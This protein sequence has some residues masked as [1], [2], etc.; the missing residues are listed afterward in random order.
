MLRD[1][2]AWAEI[3]LSAIHKNVVKLKQMTRPN[4]RFMAVVKADGYGHGAF[5]VAR[6]ALS[7]GATNIGV[8]TID[9]AIALRKAGIIEPI[10]VLS[11][12]P[13]D[14][15]LKLV[16][17]NIT[18]T[19]FTPEF[20]F[21]LGG[22][23]NARG[24]KIPFH[25][26]I[27]TGMNRIG[28]NPLD[29]PGFLESF[30]FHKGLKL[31][32]VF[33]H[34]ATADIPGD[35]ELNA[36]LERFKDAIEAIKALN[37][38]PGIVHAANSAALILNPRTHFDMVRVGIAMYGLHPGRATKDVVALTPAMSIKGR[39][40]NAKRVGLGEGVGYGFSYHAS[41][42]AEIGVIPI[43]Y[44]DGLHRILS[45]EMSVLHD[46]RRVRQVGNICMDQCMV[47]IA[48]HERRAYPQAKPF[49]I[50]DEVVIVG[51]Q[52]VETITLD[53]LAELA[54]TINYELAC[55]FG[56]RLYRTYT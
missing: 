54:G 37:I 9:E 6:E 33:T 11:Q 7:A 24:I 39:L 43:G 41:T 17:Y 26:K 18:P 45:N 16:E 47:E 44:G 29:A 51:S 12:P 35:W 5:E 42:S 36:Q 13:E 1:R 27:D 38:D 32:G 20:A 19:V 3:D 55:D 15:I 30:T 14:S 4:T 40:T 10:L 2:W 28:I 25:L 46:G 23:G 21:A 48:G 22:F 8:A 53:E 56:L 49:E 50:G 31:E 52:G 34:F